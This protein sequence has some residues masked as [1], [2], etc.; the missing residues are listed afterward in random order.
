MCVT[1]DMEFTNINEN[2]LISEL[3]SSLELIFADVVRR[4][5]NNVEDPARTKLMMILESEDLDS[6]II[7]PLKVLNEFTAE[8]IVNQISAVIQ[9]HQN[10]KFSS[11]IGVTVGSITYNK[12]IAGYNKLIEISGN[13]I[14]CLKRRRHIVAFDD[15]PDSDVNC[16]MR[17][18]CYWY[19]VNMKGHKF[20][21]SKKLKCENF[22]KYAI[23]VAKMCN[24]NWN[25]PIDL[26]KVPKIEQSL[27]SMIILIQFTRNCSGFEYMYRGNENFSDNKMYILIHPPYSSSMLH[28]VAIKNPAQFLWGNC[29]NKIMCDNCKNIVNPEHM[30]TI[31]KIKIKCY[32]CQRKDCKEFIS[33]QKTPTITCR[34]C[35]YSFLGSGCYESHFL[36]IGKRKP[37]CVRRYRCMQ[38]FY[39][40]TDGTP[41][42]LHVHGMKKCSHCKALVF[43]SLENRHIC[44]LLVSKPEKCRKER[45]I[46]FDIESAMNVEARCDSPD[47]G[48]DGICKNC[49][50]HTC[51]V[52]IHRP[53]A[54]VSFSCCELC[55]ERWNNPE[56]P[57]DPCE[58]C[59]WRCSKCSGKNA[60]L[61]S[62]RNSDSHSNYCGTRRVSFIGPDCIKLFID[63]ILDKRRMNFSL[64][65][66]AASSYDNYFIL[67][68]LEKSN[69]HPSELIMSGSKVIYFKVN[70]INLKFYDSFKLFCIPLKDLP[71]ALLNGRYSSEIAKQRFPMKLL[72][73]STLSYVGPFPKESD[74][75]TDRMSQSE[76]EQ[77]REWLDS[78]KH[79]TFNMRQVLLSYCAMD[80]FILYLSLLAFQDLV[81]ECTSCPHLPEGCDPLDNCMTISSLALKIFRQVYIKEHHMATLHNTI[82]KD[83]IIVKATKQ[84]RQFTF[85]L[86]DAGPTTE[87]NLNDYEIVNT[88]IVNSSLRLLPPVHYDPYRRNQYSEEGLA[89]VLYYERKLISKYG[90]DNVKSFHILS[91]GERLVRLD[92]IGSK[93][94][95][96]AVFIIKQAN[97]KEIRHCLNYHGCWH[98]FFYLY[99]LKKNPRPPRNSN[100]TKRAPF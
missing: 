2:T 31:G 56:G 17:A 88:S 67:Q 7:I 43:D 98:V 95:P 20:W 4:F 8:Y 81:K 16:F 71:K 23:N 24:V 33:G 78:R 9:S 40:P 34:A 51:T 73:E 91:Y 89:C 44:H 83:D 82:T 93:T 86:P 14:S 38:C 80:S 66:H 76:L 48:D 49:K 10:L 27:K 28:A 55:R 35:S 77:F 29:A 19:F 69:F 99:R 92:R 46:S 26:A 79:D 42:D 41:R 64:Y 6:P 70:R 96:D 57:G 54:I 39:T 37:L 97:G 61:C 58:S 68:E 59:G 36:G 87:E 18:V 45:I 47:V 50:N 85:D 32:S 94:Y 30:C 3:F 74:F 75:I 52:K 15:R 65:A 84:G 13:K 21:Y 22:D 12:V 100:R 5:R 60:K 1:Y 11:G 63:Y 90:I 53:L 62:P 25:S 72:R